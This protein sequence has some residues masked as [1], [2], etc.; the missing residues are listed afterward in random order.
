M[1]KILIVGLGGAGCAIAQ[2][3]YKLTGIRAV[4]VN[5]DSK[6]LQSLAVDAFFETL[7][8]GSKLCT[9]R[10]ANVPALGRRAAEESLVELNGLLKNSHFLVVTVGLGGGTGT[11]ALSILLQLAQAQGMEILVAATLPFAF[12]TARRETALAALSELEAT[13]VEVLIHDLKQADKYSPPEL[14]FAQANME[15]AQDVAGWLRQ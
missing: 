3:V 11:G 9:R 1:K 2:A 13:G 7:L 6:A 10:A 8:L 4:A 14:I 15:I 5:T 12:E